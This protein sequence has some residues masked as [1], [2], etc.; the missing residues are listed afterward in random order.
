[1]LGEKARLYAEHEFDYGNV[2]K[3]WD[4]TL[5]KCIN[6]WKANKPKSWTCEQLR[7]FGK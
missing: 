3:A 2:I 1:M 4:A 7:P 5:D 6:D